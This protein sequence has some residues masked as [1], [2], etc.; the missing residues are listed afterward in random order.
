MNFF[1]SNVMFHMPIRRRQLKL[2]FILYFS[3]SINC[4]DRWKTNIYI[5]KNAFIPVAWNNNKYDVYA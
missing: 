1:V 5:S 3:T 4:D 2:Q